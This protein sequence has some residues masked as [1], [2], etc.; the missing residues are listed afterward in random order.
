MYDHLFWEMHQHGRITDASTEAAGARSRANQVAHEM[1]YLRMKVDRLSLACQAMW[2]LLQ[3]DGAFEEERLLDKIQEVD[4]RDG[5]ADG[6][7]GASPIACPDCGRM[8]NSRR[9]ACMYCGASLTDG[10]KHVFE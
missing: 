3:D 5:R 4:L 7:I 2:E 8:A 9:R 10:Q 1:D 6:K